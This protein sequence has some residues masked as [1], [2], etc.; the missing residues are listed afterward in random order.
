MTDI[1]HFYKVKLRVLLELGYYWRA[2]LIRGFTVSGCKILGLGP[3]SDT[4][5]D[6]TKIAVE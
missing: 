1:A 4:E 5:A 6:S 2:S 3:N